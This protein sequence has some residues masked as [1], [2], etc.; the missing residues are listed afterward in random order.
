MPAVWSLTK[1]KEF[2]CAKVEKFPQKPFHAP[3]LVQLF[4]AGWPI[5][6]VTSKAITSFNSSHRH[7]CDKRRLEK[8]ISILNKHCKTREVVVTKSKFLLHIIPRRPLWVWVL[9]GAARPSRC[10]P[11]LWPTHVVGTRKP[12]ISTDSF[13]SQTPGLASLV[14]RAQSSC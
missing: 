2:F 14:L 4:P 5:V 11:L 9:F 6:R 8:G 10:L 1:S 7:P 12:K 3:C 13:T